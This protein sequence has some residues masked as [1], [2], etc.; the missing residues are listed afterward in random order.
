M[1][2]EYP[3]DYVVQAVLVRKTMHSLDFFANVLD[4]KNHSGII[5]SSQKI[6]DL[7]FVCP[8]EMTGR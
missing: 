8:P 5:K 1:G 2:W 3:P 7:E 6:T 4:T